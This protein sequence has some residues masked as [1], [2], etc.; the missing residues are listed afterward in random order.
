MKTRAIKLKDAHFSNFHSEVVGKWNYADLVSGQHPDWFHDWVSFDC[1]LAD[2]ARDTIWCGLTCLATDIFYRYDRKHDRF[3]SMNFQQVADRYDAKFHRSLLFDDDGGMWAATALLHDIDR[4]H[5]A[6]GGAL[7]HFDP[8][9]EQLKIVARPMPHHYIQSITMDRR[10]GIIYGL[11]FTPERLFSY[12]VATGNVTDLGPVGSG[13][14]MAQGQT[15]VID[16]QGTCWGTWGVTRAWLYERGPD[17][18][19]LWRYR[20]DHGRIEYLD[21]GLPRLHGRTGSAGLDGAHLGPDGV[22]YMGTVEGLLCRLDPESA[23]VEAIGKPGPARR[24]AGMANGPDG[25][26]Y[27]SAGQDGSVVLFRYDPANRR[28]EQLG[29]VYDPDIREYAWHIHDLA[30]TNDGVIYAGENDAPHRSSYLWE[31]SGAL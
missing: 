27:G 24:L 8:V 12:E 3:A 17:E 18:F 21:H 4:Y 15:V 29:P 2:D 31:I 22:L 23:Q 9:S 25:K 1:L 19:R 5:D 14:A 20:P 16:R 28:I 30:I 6:P 7:V 11:T 10:R 26:L 13:F